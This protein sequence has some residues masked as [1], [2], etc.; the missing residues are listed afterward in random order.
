MSNKKTN[1]FKRE[2]TY[3]HYEPQISTCK[4]TL[5]WQTENISELTTNFL[6][7]SEYVAKL[8]YEH[9]SN[10]HWADINRVIKSKS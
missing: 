3:K 10:I 6:K 7:A 4:E 9:M 1:D 2:G 8:Q 5:K